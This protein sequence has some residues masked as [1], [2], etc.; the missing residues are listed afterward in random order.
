MVDFKN[1]NLRNWDRKSLEG[2]AAFTG[3]LADQ[4]IKDDKLK[5]L[6]E[7]GQKSAEEYVAQVKAGHRPHTTSQLTPAQRKARDSAEA[8]VQK[9]LNRPK[10]KK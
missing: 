10:L 7:A 3:M 4:N 1:I 2:L 6:K 5:K 8:Y 9:L